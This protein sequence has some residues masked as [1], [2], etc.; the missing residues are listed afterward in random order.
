MKR[1]LPP[2]LVELGNQLEAAAARALARRRVRRQQILNAVASLV[3]AVP[4]VISI[5]TNQISSGEAPVAAPSPTPTSTAD[6]A[7]VGAVAVPR[8]SLV[9]DDMLPRDLTRMHEAPNSELLILPTSL[10]P[11]LR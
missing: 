4:L 5:A 6:A 9:R 7:P 11:A 10:R 1:P 3:V 2:E 8:P